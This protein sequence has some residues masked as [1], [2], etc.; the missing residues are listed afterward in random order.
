MAAASGVFPAVRISHPR[1]NLRVREPS[2]PAD[3]IRRI[4]IIL[5]LITYTLANIYM[6][7]DER[8]R[9]V[10]RK[11]PFAPFF[12]LPNPILYGLDCYFGCI[13]CSRDRYFVRDWGSQPFARRKSGGRH[14]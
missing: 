10:V 12:W 7:L 6:T 9:V 11:E 2:V 3:A 5:G 4:V 14:G 13:R 1:A 8:R